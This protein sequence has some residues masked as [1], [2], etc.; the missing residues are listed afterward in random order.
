MNWGKFLSPLIA[1]LFLTTL[2][3]SCGGNNDEFAPVPPEPGGMVMSIRLSSSAF[4]NGEPIPAKYSRDGD[5]MSPP[6]QWS[7]PPDGTQSLALIVDDPDAPHGTWIHW[8]VFNLPAQT[9]ALPEAANSQNN[10]PTGATQGK[11]SWGHT[12]YEGP[13][14]PGGIHHYYF[15]LY[16]IDTVIDLKAWASKTDLLHAMNQHLLAKGE[17]MGTYQK[18]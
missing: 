7:D 12:M 13:D 5:N 10:L 4:D 9:R 14:P 2:L 8:V 17:L 11:N 18:K 16:A 3:T 6:L 1:G 15:K